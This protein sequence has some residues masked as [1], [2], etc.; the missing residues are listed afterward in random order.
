MTEYFEEVES[1]MKKYK[2]KPFIIR[3]FIGAISNRIVEFS[4]NGK[5]YR[6]KLTRGIPQGACISPVAWVMACSEIIEQ[7]P[8]FRTQLTAFADDFFLQTVG[9][10]M[11]CIQENLQRSVNLVDNWTRNKGI[12]FNPDKSEVIIFQKRK[13]GPDLTM[14]PIKLGGKDI[15]VVKVINYRHLSFDVTLEKKFKACMI[16]LNKVVK[17]FGQ[18][19]KAGFRPVNSH[20]VYTQ[21]V[22]S[23]LTY[24]SYIICNKVNI[25]V[26][27]K[28]ADRLQR[29]AVRM[30]SHVR[31]KSPT[32]AIEVI[33]RLPPLDLIIHKEAIRTL[34]K[35]RNTHPHLCEANYGH[36][37]FIKQLMEKQGMDWREEWDPKYGD[38]FVEKKFRVNFNRTW[39]LKCNPNQVKGFSDG[40]KYKG[41]VGAGLIIH[42][43]NKKVHEKAFYLGKNATVFQAEAIG[44]Q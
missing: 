4:Y 33:N 34:V 22:R 11:R 6:R 21:C 44:L 31:Q 18:S 23:L 14:E 10:K 20:W 38:S 9:K 39:E 3:A 29:T 32:A 28:E 26:F 41:H 17:R 43:Y 35:M 27:K 16:K 24:G 40:S 15:K 19:G 12:E 25:R 2:L 13:K 7:F 8:K 30:F 42:H 5:N 36:V 37:G 1:G